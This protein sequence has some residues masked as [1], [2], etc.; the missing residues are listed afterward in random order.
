MTESIDSQK[1]ALRRTAK[2]MAKKL[3]GNDISLT[4]R[5]HFITRY[6]AG[7]TGALAGYCPLPDEAD[8]MPLLHTLS[9]TG[10]SCGLPV[11][12]EKQAPLIFRHWATGDELTKGAFAT[13]QP[14]D[15]KPV[16]R[17]DI[18]LV[19]MLAFDGKGAR[20]GRGAGFYDRTLALLRQTSSILAIGVAYAEQKLDFV[21]TDAHD[22]P[23]DA[24]L[25]QHGFENF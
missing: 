14:G 6:G 2:K 21:P 25:T 18:L 7:P 11:V 15:G 23:L 1:R 8:V 17:P 9:A 20:L 16:I 3:A 24:V 12:G 22:Q 19:P 13:M 4:L 5:D 10:W